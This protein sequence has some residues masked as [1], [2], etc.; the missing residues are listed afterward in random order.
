[1]LKRVTVNGKR[2]PVPVPVKTLAEALGWIESTLVLPGHSV[3]RVTIDDRCLDEND[4]LSGGRDHMQLHEHT[5]LEVR[6][7]SPV[8]LA[9]QTLDAIRNLASA[10]GVSLKP[11]AVEMWQ[12]RPG[13]RSPEFDGLMQDLQLMLELIEHVSGL[14][15]ASVDIAP[16][17]GISLLLKRALVGAQ[18]AKSNSDWK[19]A[20]KIL[21][22]RI[23][24]Q[25]KELI[26]ETETLQL[27]ILSTQGAALTA[28]RIQHPTGQSKAPTG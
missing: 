10:V 13:Y 19:A 7:D 20:A 15:D 28:G 5:R 9:V 8:E 2:V 3:T 14:V 27:R 21:L 16:L 11:L 26:S 23:E 4:L 22:N 24:S 6:I 1:M 17:Q 12:A 25:L 18:M